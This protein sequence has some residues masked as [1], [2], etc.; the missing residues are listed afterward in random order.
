MTQFIGVEEMRRLVR[1]TGT[2]AFLTQLAGYVRHDFSRWTE[3]EKSARVASLSR[4]GVNRHLS[5][6]QRRG[7][8][9]LAPGACRIC[10]RDALRTIALGGAETDAGP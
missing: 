9:A 2:K 7:W 3:F 8:I 1:S 5:V 6:W 4:E 10:D